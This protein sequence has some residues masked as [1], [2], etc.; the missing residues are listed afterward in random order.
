MKVVCPVCS[1]SL[2]QPCDPAKDA[3]Y[4]RWMLSYD[5]E[6]HTVRCGN[7]G[8]QYQY[9]APTGEVNARPDGSGC[10]HEY[11]SETIGRCLTRHTCKHCND[12]YVIDSGD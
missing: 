1:G 5:K 7:C 8:G 10:V 2:R 6:N 9:G 3:S 12:R 4:Y 11:E